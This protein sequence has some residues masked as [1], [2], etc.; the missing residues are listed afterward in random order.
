MTRMPPV[1]YIPMCH[2]SIVDT[3]G[4]FD[5]YH[6]YIY[7]VFRL[8]YF[9][10]NHF[11]HCWHTYVQSLFTARLYMRPY[12]FNDRV[13]QIAGILFWPGSSYSKV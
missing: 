13:L 6:L 2:T 4:L 3:N 8:L 11:N 10:H 7:F 5:R 12:V 1:V 9:T